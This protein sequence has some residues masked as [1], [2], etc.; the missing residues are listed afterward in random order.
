MRA[1]V[2]GVAL[3]GWLAG[4]AGEAAPSKAALWTDAKPKRGPKHSPE[5]GRVARGAM[6]AVVS[7]SVTEADTAASSDPD[8][9]RG[10]GAGFIIHEDGLILTSSHVVEGARDIQV[11]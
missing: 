4:T 5:I 6:K 8:G 9:Q 10:I 11:S 3:I 1:M 7:I 2:A